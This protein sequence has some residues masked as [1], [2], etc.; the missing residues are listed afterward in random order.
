[1]VQ[2]CS[3]T[4][5]KIPA[6]VAS[7]VPVLCSLVRGR[8]VQP[9]SCLGIITAWCQWV[10]ANYR[11]PLNIVLTTIY[12]SLLLCKN[13]SHPLHFSCTPCCYIITA[14]TFCLLNNALE[15]CCFLVLLQA[16]RAWKVL[17]MA[18]TSLS[19][20]KSIPSCTSSVQ[21][22]LMLQAQIKHKSGTP[23]CLLVQISG[24]HEQKGAS[25]TSY[26]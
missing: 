12:G 13:N 19:K 16:L 23:V 9:D 5:P 25:V 11:I 7:L 2:Q 26:S 20:V 22:N 10:P 21:M 8:E 14:E 6:A 4:V 24:I 15:C 3:R 18:C 1:M 17:V